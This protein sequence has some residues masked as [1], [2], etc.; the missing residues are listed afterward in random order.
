MGSIGNPISACRQTGHPCSLQVCARKWPLRLA[1]DVSDP[2]PSRPF[3]AVGRNV[4]LRLLL[5]LDEVVRVP[6][7]PH[8]WSSRA[9]MRPL[10]VVLAVSIT[11]TKPYMAGG[12]AR[13]GARNPPLTAL[14]PCQLSRAGAKEPLADD[15]SWGASENTTTPDRR[16]YSVV[17]RP[18]NT[19]RFKCGMPS[20][21]RKFRR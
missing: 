20:V 2:L 1:E 6:L 4:L 12:P 14:T 15:Q 3:P 5:G 8:T 10:I 16:K 11:C 9:A 21:A 7:V 17:E 13:A 19:N 18:H